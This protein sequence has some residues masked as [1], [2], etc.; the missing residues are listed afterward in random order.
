[1]LEQAPVDPVRRQPAAE[2]QVDRPPRVRPQVGPGFELVFQERE[3]PAS[4]GDAD[5]GNRKDGHVEVP[6]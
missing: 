6:L 3:G 2:T 1:M 5:G 4:L